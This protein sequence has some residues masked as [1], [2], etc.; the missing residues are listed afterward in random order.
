M[1]FPRR[2]LDDIVWRS[3]AVDCGVRPKDANILSVGEMKSR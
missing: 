2:S 1:K 3:I